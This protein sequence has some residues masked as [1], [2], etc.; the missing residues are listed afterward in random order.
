MELPK[1]AITDEK[2][3]RNV[4][5]IESYY[6]SEQDSSRGIIVVQT[7]NELIKMDE[8]GEQLQ[9]EIIEVDGVKVNLYNFDCKST[10]QLILWWYNGEVSR[11][12]T[13]FGDENIQET[14][15]MIK[16]ILNKKD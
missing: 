8:K 6:I 16:T 5:R 1:E 2:A 4:T 12:L 3:R 14:K 7:S 9:V 13:T 15:E 11:D 10:N